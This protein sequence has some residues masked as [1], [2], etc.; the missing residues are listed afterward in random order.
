MKVHIVTAV[1][2]ASL[3]LLE[4][5]TST[6]AQDELPPRVKV[7]VLLNLPPWQSWVHLFW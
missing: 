6:A 2:A 1:V 5:N 3:A 7:T 4:G